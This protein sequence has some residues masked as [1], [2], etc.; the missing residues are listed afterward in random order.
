[1][2][3]ENK[4]LYERVLPGRSRAKE[5]LIRVLFVFSYLAFGA[6]LTLLCLA[7]HALLYLAFLLPL[8]VG[9]LAFLTLPFWKKQYEYSFFGESL[10][11]SRIYGGKRRKVLV[12]LNLRDAAAIFPFEE[13]FRARAEAFGARHS[14]Y[15]V[16]DL[17]AEHLYLILFGEGKE[18]SILCVALDQNS[19]AIIG[20]YNRAALTK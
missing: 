7:L 11:V 5:V 2:A 16:P 12:E 14:L 3:T 17:A 4:R 13:E 19:L 20:F 8:G 1:M 15:A 18:K 10:T 9:L 6:L